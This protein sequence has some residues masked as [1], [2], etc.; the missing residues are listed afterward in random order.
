MAEL[1]LG[2]ALQES[3]RN[4]QG[5]ECLPGGGGPAGGLPHRLPVT[6][7]MRSPGVQHGM[8]LGQSRPGVG[9]AQSC[10]G[11]HRRD[12]EP[13]RQ[14][15]RLTAGSWPRRP[16]EEHEHRQVHGQHHLMADAVE[17]E[18]ERREHEVCNQGRERRHREAGV[19]GGR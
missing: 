4:G 5:V 14:P 1:P 18:I 17:R 6:G 19:A 16:L 8:F 13:A 2:V 12:E 11:G 10:R 7:M 9:T 3:D 15:D